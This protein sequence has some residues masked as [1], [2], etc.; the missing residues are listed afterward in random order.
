MT[1]KFALQVMYAIFNCVIST[2]RNITWKGNKIKDCVHRKCVMYINI[3]HLWL[4]L[5][6]ET[7]LLPNFF[8]VVGKWIR[9]CTRMPATNKLCCASTFLDIWMTCLGIWL[10]H[11]SSNRGIA[12]YWSS[13]TWRHRTGA[14]G[15]TT[16]RTAQSTSDAIAK[17]RRNTWYE[18]SRLSP[19]HDRRMTMKWYSLTCQVDESRALACM[20]T[21]LVRRYSSAPTSHHSVKTPETTE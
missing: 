9:H 3:C 13:V 15:A 5:S 14:N 16:V 10:H 4:R 20:V 2:R 1:C 17:S 7:A 8:A 12:H 11:L 19:E 6:T 21:R 18:A